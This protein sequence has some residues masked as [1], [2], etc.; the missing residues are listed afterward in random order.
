[1]SK[2]VSSGHK[3]I[4][5]YPGRTESEQAGLSANAD[6]RTGGTYTKDSRVTNV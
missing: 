6:A 1:M 4:K 2:K 3:V 5:N